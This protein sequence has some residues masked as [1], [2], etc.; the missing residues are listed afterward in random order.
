MMYFPSTKNRLKLKKLDKNCIQSIISKE[1]RRIVIFLRTRVWYFFGSFCFTETIISHWKLFFFWL[2]LCLVKWSEKKLSDRQNLVVW[3]PTQGP[4]LRRNTLMTSYSDQ[5][6]AAQE[7]EPLVAEETMLCS[8]LE[9]KS[10]LR[11]VC[12]LQRLNW[13]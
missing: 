2:F 13:I 7:L 11:S 9:S 10:P 5:E 4:V 3:R 8:L 6:W 1:N 12:Q